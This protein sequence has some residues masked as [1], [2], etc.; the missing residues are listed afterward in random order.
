MAGQQPEVF[1]TE[2]KEQPPVFLGVYNT[3]DEAQ[4]ATSGLIAESSV[5][6]K[7]HI[8][9]GPNVYGPTT[10]PPEGVVVLTNRRIQAE[11]AP[12]SFYVVTVMK[13][14]SDADDDLINRVQRTLGRAS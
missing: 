7:F 2:R 8:Y 13:E 3:A 12:H 9:A 6:Q 14:P 11:V 10:Q 4:R 1:V 5:K